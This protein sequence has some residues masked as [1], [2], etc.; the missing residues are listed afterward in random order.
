MRATGS[1]TALVVA[2]AIAGC[3]AED[4][5]PES[6]SL[7]ATATETSSITTEAETTT[8]A[9]S[10][11]DYPGVDVTTSHIAAARL[12]IGEA[13]DFIE[14]VRLVSTPGAV[15]NLVIVSTW[16]AG[17][18]D[19][20]LVEAMCAGGQLWAVQIS[21]GE[22]TISVAPMDYSDAFTSCSYP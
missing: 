13:V 21:I 1:L 22:L 15:P 6:A 11:R 20:A 18:Q 16:L 9:P 19:A 8:A 2:I 14:T 4:P 10:A 5:A 12:S 7:S 3:A 17:E